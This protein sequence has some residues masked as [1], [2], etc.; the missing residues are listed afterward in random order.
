MSR[1]VLV[2]GVV[3][4]EGKGVEEPAGPKCPGAPDHP[5][6]AYTTG[7]D[8]IDSICLDLGSIPHHIYS[9]L[10]K[11]SVLSDTLPIP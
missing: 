5:D 4:V 3:V 6:R 11:S 10:L 8:L 7:R 1:R 9:S 2:V